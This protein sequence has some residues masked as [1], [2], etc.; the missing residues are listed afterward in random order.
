MSTLFGRWE[1]DFRRAFHP[2]QAENVPQAAVD[3]Q[4]IR[5][6]FKE[7]FRLQQTSKWAE[8][9][10]EFEF[11]I[12]NYEAVL[13]EAHDDIVSAK[14]YL[15][16]SYAEMEQ[17]SVAE[18]LWKTCE[19][20]SI[21]KLGTDNPVT[22]D[23][24]RKLFTVL[25]DQCQWI[26]AKEKGEMYLSILDR[27]QG[28]EA[29]RTLGVVLQLGSVYVNLHAY[30]KALEYHRRA[31]AGF[32]RGVGFK[33]IETIH[34]QFKLGAVY[35]ELGDME[36]AANI[37]QQ[38]R[39]ICAS[40][41]GITNEAYLRAAVN[42]GSVQRSG[43]NDVEAEKTLLSLLPD[44]GPNQLDR[45][46][47]R[48]IGRAANELVMLYNRLGRHADARK[49]EEWISGNVAPLLEIKHLKIQRTTTTWTPR[50][51]DDDEVGTHQLK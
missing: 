29:F 39:D 4:P 8:A 37:Y 22:L 19:E 27:T 42:L 26:K 35:G 7:G 43:G 16:V 34:A 24:T 14:G 40:T 21:K 25:I 6:A 28:P 1:K 31:L 10:K 46:W 48:Y 17:F 18:S 3:L 2:D 23:Y 11:C 13:G 38:N 49:A 44:T 41:R 5:A 51:G 50:V 30:T 20:V 15:G 32:E 36:K 9:A 12:A 47:T 33:N 45:Y